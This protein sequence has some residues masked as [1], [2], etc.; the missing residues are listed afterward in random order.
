MDFRVDVYLSK[1]ANSGI[2]LT[3]QS[4]N[5]IFEQLRQTVKYE[6]IER[7]LGDLIDLGT[8]AIIIGSLV[9]GFYGLE[10]VVKDAHKT[11]DKIVNFSTNSIVNSLELNNL[12]K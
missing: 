4:R 6:N 12:S 10:N 11:N 2:K 7:Y 9:G 3:R 8:K 1:L 5:Y